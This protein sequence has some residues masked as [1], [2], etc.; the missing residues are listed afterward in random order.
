MQKICILVCIFGVLVLRCAVTEKASVGMNSSGMHRLSGYTGYIGSLAPST[1]PPSRSRYPQVVTSYDALNIRLSALKASY[2]DNRDTFLPMKALFE[3]SIFN[4]FEVNFNDDGRDDVYASL[5]YEVADITNLKTV[6]KTLT[7]YTDQSSRDCALSLLYRLRASAMYIREIM[8]ENEGIL[9]QANLNVLQHSNNL[10][11]LN[12]L[13]S[14][15]DEMLRLRNIVVDMAKGMLEMAVK[16]LGNANIQLE[17]DPI[18]SA[19]GKLKEIINSG[20]KL[21]LRDLRT[22]IEI[23]VNNLRLQ[24]LRGQW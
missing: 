22:K 14:Y 7:S 15:L 10:R 21:S 8:D 12:L 18:T 2:N 23:T 11:G 6:I 1:P 13:N 3:S 16:V 5:R 24:V 9:N 4:E 19:Q 17:L 20:T